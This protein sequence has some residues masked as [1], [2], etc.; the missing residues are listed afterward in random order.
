MTLRELLHRGNWKTACSL[1]GINE[2][3]V[4]EGRGSSEV[5]LTEEEAV[6]C[7]ITFMMDDTNG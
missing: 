5:T 3:A 1:L 6:K 7:G 4:N 2:W